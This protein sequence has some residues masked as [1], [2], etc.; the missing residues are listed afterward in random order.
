MGDFGIGG[1]VGVG[2]STVVGYI[3]NFRGKWIVCIRACL[4]ARIVSI[5]VE[6]GIDGNVEEAH[7]FG[8]EGLVCLGTFAQLLKEIA[9]DKKVGG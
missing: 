9:E 1:N 5:G 7:L 3:C 6:G 4:A 2:A 8:N